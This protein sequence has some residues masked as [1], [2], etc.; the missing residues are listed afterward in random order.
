VPDGLVALCTG[1]AF[2]RISY[3][4]LKSILA[5]YLAEVL[6]GGEARLEDIWLLP[7]LAQL[8]GA[9]GIALSGI[10]TGTFLS[11]AVLAPAI[12]SILADRLLG[13]HRAIMAGGI[14]MAGGHGLLVLE[15]AVLPALALIA[16][17]AGLFKG[18]VAARLSGLYAQDDP[19][20]VEGFRLFYFAVN[21][22]GLVAP[23]V[24]GT[25]GERVSWHA[26]FAVSCA[27]ML[28]GLAIYR[29]RFGADVAD[30][31]Q[32]VEAPDET[33]AGARTDLAG[34][35]ILCLSVALICVPNSQ[36]TNAYL[37]WAKQG[38]VR[39][40][41]GWEFPASWMIAADGFVSLFALAATGLFWR[42]YEQSRG[43]VSAADKAL[44]GAGFV[45]AGAALL[46]L[47]SVVHGRT[48]VPVGWGLA[49]QLCNSLGL[50]N[51]FPAAMAIFGQAS[52]RKHASTAMAGFFLALFAG[53][54]VS[55]ALASGFA[56][57]P[58]TT[59]WMLHALCVLCGAIGLTLY[60]SGSLRQELA[61]S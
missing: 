25:L 35:A 34:L 5:L 16:L 33:A 45:I 28:T 47:A 40:L 8:T 14:M 39:S 44:A 3:Y 50:A 37:L 12:G 49:F 22:A 51:V 41:W 2:E 17:G 6:A 42:R 48:G 56:T 21:I 9:Q 18:P 1:I 30:D 57:L 10:I 26:G 43:A 11:V 4:G 61:Q 38:F 24:I 60:R 29:L 20:R 55:T 58:I 52:T 31:E 15:A 7:A 23:L 46:V 36:L 13:Q 32:A 27:A 19:R 54:L 53:G 59:F